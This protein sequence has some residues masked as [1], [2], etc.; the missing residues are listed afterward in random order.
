MGPPLN[1]I[2]S[3]KMPSSGSGAAGRLGAQFRVRPV[4]VGDE[5]FELDELAQVYFPGGLDGRYAGGVAILGHVPDGPQVVE[6]AVQCL[7]SADGP[8]DDALGAE[9]SHAFACGDVAG[10]AP[11]TMNG[12]PRLNAM[13]PVN[14]SRRSGI[15]TTTSFVVRAGLT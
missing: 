8:G 13:S 11:W 4:Q 14:M 1:S 5:A 15:H 7:R 3:A 9:L 12:V 10:E 2:I 6:H